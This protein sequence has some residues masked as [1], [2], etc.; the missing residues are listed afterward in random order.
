MSAKHMLS[1]YQ[2][3]VTVHVMHQIHEVGGVYEKGKCSPGLTIK[4]IREIIPD[5]VIS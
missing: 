2:T 4:Q 1:K 5:I 3:K